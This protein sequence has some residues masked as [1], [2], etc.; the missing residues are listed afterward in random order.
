MINVCIRFNIW[1]ILRKTDFCIANIN[2]KMYKLTKFA[3]I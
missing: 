1:N 3:D 2:V